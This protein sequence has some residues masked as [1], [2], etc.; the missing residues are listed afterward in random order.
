MGRP[1]HDNVTRSLETYAHLG[2]MQP[3]TLGKGRG[4]GSRATS[5]GLHRAP[6][7]R[8]SAGRLRWARSRRSASKCSAAVARALDCRFGVVI[9]RIC[10]TRPPKS[11]RAWGPWRSRAHTSVC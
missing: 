11:S 6:S 1:A 9:W 5:S 7:S 3:G 4:S 10:D 8:G 2:E